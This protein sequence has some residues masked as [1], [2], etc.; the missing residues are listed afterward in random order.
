MAAL[1]CAATMMSVYLLARNQSEAALPRR[2]GVDSMGFVPWSASSSVYSHQSVYGETN[3]VDVLRWRGSL[4]RR[5][6]ASFGLM[7]SVGDG[8]RHTRITLNSNG[9]WFGLFA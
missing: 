8:T 9:Y 7:V 3:A 2:V 4:Y 5:E 1:V 6:H